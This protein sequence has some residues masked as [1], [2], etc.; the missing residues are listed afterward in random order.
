MELRSIPAGEQ[1]LVHLTRQ[2]IADLPEVAVP[3]GTTLFG[4]L[5]T[6]GTDQVLI[7]VAIGVQRSAM[8]ATTLGQD[9]SIATSQIEDAAIRRLSRPRTVL[10]VVGGIGS[11][12][13]LGYAFGQVRNEAGPDDPPEEAFRIPLFSL[14]LRF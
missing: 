8:S 3:A 10:T 7:R 1:V 4:R 9:V 5:M 6:N 2:G 11:I 14:P 12:A 13:I